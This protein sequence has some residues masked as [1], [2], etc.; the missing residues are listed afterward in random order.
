[1]MA[2]SEQ[3]GGMPLARL[4]QDFA[5]ADAAA[6]LEAAA[7]VG[8]VSADSRDI[9]PGDLF[10]ACKGER[11]DGA[12]YIDAAIRAGA[13]AIAIEEGLAAPA[14]WPAPMFIVP[15]LAR[16]AGP[17][18]A[19][20]YGHP[21][22]YLSLT[23]VTGT[24]GKTSVAWWLA[25]LSTR[26]SGKPCGLI[27]T[28]GG[29]VFPRLEA[30]INTTPGAV[31]LQKRMAGFAQ[32]RIGAVF[33]EV[34]SHALAQGRVEG[35]EF[36]TAV[37][38]NLSHEH[39]DY[40]GD[41][42]AYRECKAALFRRPEL[43]C[44]ILNVDDAV[45]RDL[46]AELRDG[47]R[48]M[49][50]SLGARRPAAAAAGRHLQATVKAAANDSIAVTV[51]GDFGDGVFTTERPG[52]FNVANMLAATAALLR[53]GFPLERILAALGGA[54]PVPGRME[55]FD[56]PGGA[57]AFVDYAHTP[58]ALEQA[59]A[60]LRDSCAGALIC[61]FGCGGGR[62]REKRPRMGSVAARLA[63][64]VIVTDDNP[65]AEPPRQIVDEI[66]AGMEGADNNARVIVEQNRSA[67]IRRAVEEARDGD[68]ILIAGK[69]HET[70]QEIDGR[71]FPFSD[72]QQARNCALPQPMR[73]PT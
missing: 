39:L 59:L 21:S 51:G 28:L 25:W 16:K 44:A 18:A 61:V 32:A 22:R 49:T 37:F 31:A 10:L 46:A 30:G 26:L 4:L 33:M 65:R 70:F 68:V 53:A 71:R 11:G 19:R 35:L 1:M 73:K 54:P 15:D 7:P 29:G 14:S 3:S 6:A 42:R 67:A 45:G 55:R 34:S 9:A 62:D 69:G 66:L 20:C 12:A 72:R 24:N 47:P 40:H 64:R 8:G 52:P 17:I 13:A 50:Y 43:E 23:G 36:N 5:A 38:T 57:R 48:I 56:L 63:D 41:L 60:A 58:A 27:G 2:L